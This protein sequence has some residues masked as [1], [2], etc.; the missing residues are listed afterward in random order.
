MAAAGPVAGSPGEGGSPGDPAQLTGRRRHAQRGSGRRDTGS[1]DVRPGESGDG[2]RNGGG[3]AP[4]P[5]R[6]ARQDRPTPAEAVP[7]IGTGDRAAIEAHAG[8]LPTP[9][10]GT[11]RGTMNKPQL[12]RRRAQEHIVP[13]LRGG[14][15]PRPEGDT[16]PGH[17]PGLMAAFQRGI[18][19]AEA[20]QHME[21]REPARPDAD[22][23]DSAL[24]GSAHM[25]SAHMEPAHMDSAHMDASHA[26]AP[27]MVFHLHPAATEFTE[28]PRVQ[29]DRMGSDH[30]SS[31]HMGPDHMDPTPISQG[32]TH[33]PASDGARGAGRPDG[34]APAG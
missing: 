17:D 1:G 25:E 9:R 2:R 5:V 33:A 12:P 31:D 3:L 23:L 34:S 19:L 6:G 21:S 14:P 4:L 7:G 20:Q 13:Q 10:S 15:V 16:V 30:T 22:Q 26:A 24:L 18:G 11:V 8:I 29:P 32:R 28:P 27:L